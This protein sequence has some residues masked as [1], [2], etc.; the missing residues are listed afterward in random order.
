[1]SAITTHVLDT[2]SG[3]PAAGVTVRLERRD[4]PVWLLL[5]QAETDAD[6]RCRDL[7]PATTEAGE[8]R[9]TF[10]TGPWFAERGTPAYHPEISVTFEVTG[11][12]HHH[13]PL[14]VAPFGFT[15]YRGS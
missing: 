3:R 13:V 7:G 8:H 6:G 1:M 12:G 4:G 11:D 2:A 5:A 10:A 14:L 9:L 15:T